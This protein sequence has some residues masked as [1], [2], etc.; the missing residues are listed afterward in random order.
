ML[1]ALVQKFPAPRSTA[2]ADLRGGPARRRRPVGAAPVTPARGCENCWPKSYS[3]LCLFFRAV[4]LVERHERQTS[5]RPM[6]SALGLD[7]CSARPRLAHREAR[8]RRLL[9][10]EAWCELEVTPQPV[11]KFVDRAEDLFYVC[12]VRSEGASHQWR[13][14]PPRE[15]S[16][17]LVADE[18]SGWVTGRVGA[19]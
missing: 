17:D 13:K 14:I 3:V 4:P 2:S 5:S 7:G 16:I 1:P 11:D 9:T 10:R 15:L 18:R 12:S 19:S 8:L 6:P